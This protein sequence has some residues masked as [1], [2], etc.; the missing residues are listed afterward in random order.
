MYPTGKVVAE[1]VLVDV[2]YSALIGTRYVTL[3]PGETKEISL[4]W[5][6]PD[7]AAGN[8]MLQ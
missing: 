8:I 2:S 6:L 5:D 1:N 7:L 4:I 3:Q